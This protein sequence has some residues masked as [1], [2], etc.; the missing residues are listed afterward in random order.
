MAGRK[1][2]YSSNGNVKSKKIWSVAL[3]IRLLQED[4]DNGE[5]K[6]ESN[7]V[8]SQKTLINEFVEENDDLVVYDTYVDYGFSGTDFDRPVSKKNIKSQKLKK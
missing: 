2:K 3:Y 7:S 6:I 1:S 8:T 5:G 4:S